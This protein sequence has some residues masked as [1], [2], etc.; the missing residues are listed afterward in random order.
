MGD[1]L[2]GCGKGFVENG[3]GGRRGEEDLG[4][5]KR[6]ESGEEKRGRQEDR[7]NGEGTVERGRHRR[8]GGRER[9]DNREE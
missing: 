1:G 8:K 2:V 6:E 5:V 4:G 9:Q 3:E 7:M